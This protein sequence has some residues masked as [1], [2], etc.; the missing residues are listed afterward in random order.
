M[1]R[2][3]DLPCS[4][5]LVRTPVRPFR[6]APEARRMIFALLF[7]VVLALAAVIVPAALVGA[8]LVVVSRTLLP[9]WARSVLLPVL[10]ASSAL[11]WPYA[12]GTANPWWPAAVLLSFL[13][14]CA[15]GAAFL[16]YETQDRR[17]RHPVAWPGAGHP[18]TN[19]GG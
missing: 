5:G 9:L 13:V 7:L 14:T 18:S 2:R 4:A 16:L 19:P 17:P 6:S 12:A 3:T 8:V 15:A 1:I 10:A 11:L